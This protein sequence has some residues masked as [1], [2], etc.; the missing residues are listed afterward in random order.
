MNE[1]AKVYYAKKFF[2]HLTPTCGVRAVEAALA[3]RTVP[4]PSPQPSPQGRGGRRRGVGPMLAVAL[5]LA[6]LGGS[7]GR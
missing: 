6:A 2:G 5:A 1:E 3:N 7:P 4:F